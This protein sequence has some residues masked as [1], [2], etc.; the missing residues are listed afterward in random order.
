MHEYR[1]RVVLGVGPEMKRQFHT[2]QNHAH[3]LATTTWPPLGIVS[4]QS[5]IDHPV[6]R[7]LD[8]PM[9]HPTPTQYEQSHSV[10]L[11]GMTAWRLLDVT[12]PS[13][14]RGVTILA[15]PKPQ[16]PYILSPVN[17]ETNK[18]PNYGIGA[19]RHRSIRLFLLPPYLFPDHLQPNKLQ[20]PNLHDGLGMKSKTQVPI[21]Q[22]SRYFFFLSIKV[23]VW[24]RFQ[25]R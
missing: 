19:T 3:A 20:Q 5:G 16:M 6:F 1:S 17:E 7:R 11:P 23:R 13:T 21:D 18:H 8:E 14:R 10:F 22:K 24:S 2:S 12:L 9:E 4:R 15:C 25:A